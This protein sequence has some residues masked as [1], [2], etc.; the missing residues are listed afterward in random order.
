MKFDDIHGAGFRGIFI[1]LEVCFIYCGDDNVILSQ[2]TANEVGSA[3]IVIHLPILW[4]E[5][6]TRPAADA[7]VPLLRNSMFLDSHI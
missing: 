1:R 3:V 4:C 6:N 7:F 5:E 2:L